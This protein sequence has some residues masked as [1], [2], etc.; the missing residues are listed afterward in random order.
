[1]HTNHTSNF[2]R[3]QREARKLGCPDLVELSSDSDNADHL[4]YLDILP[5]RCDAKLLPDAVAEFQGRPVMYLVDSIEGD[6]AGYNVHIADL[7]QL[8]ANRSEHACVAIFRPGQVDVYP[9]NLDR[10]LVAT[11]EPK[12]ITLRDAS[13][14]LFFH[15]IATG[16]FRLK[17]QPKEADYVFE[18]INA[19]LCHA[20]E[21][22]M[23][24]LDSLEILSLTGRALF[25]RFLVDRKIARPEDID[26]ISP[27]ARTLRHAFSNPSTASETA[28]WLDETF[29]GDLLPLVPEIYSGISDQE[30][31][32]QYRRYYRNIGERTNGAI[33]RHLEAIMRGWESVSPGEFQQPLSVDWDDLNFAHIPV[34]VLSQVYENFSHQIDSEQS[35][36]RS[37][38]YTPVKIARLMV[39]EA[40]GAIADPRKI[41]VL[42]S[43][44]GAGV[45]LVLVFRHLVRKRW[46]LDRERPRKEVIHQILYEQLTGFDVSESALRLASL[47]LYISAIEVN[48]TTRPA[49]LLKHIKPLK[50]NVLFNVDLDG[51]DGVT[52]PK[53][54]FVLGSLSDKLDKRFNGAFDVV[55]GN[56]PWTR[57]RPTSEK[58]EEKKQQRVYIASLNR[59]FDAIG[60]RVLTSRGF[61]KLAA[62]YRTPDNDPDWPFLWRAMEWAKPNGVIA[63]A[64]PARIILKQEGPGKEARDALLQ[65]VTIMG[66]LNG[67]DLEET[68]VWPNMKLPFMLLFARNCNA[69]ETHAF[70]FAT[71]VRENEL[72]RRGEFR[73]DY[74]SAH[75][76]DV[77]KVRNQ[78]WLLKT[79]AVGTVLDVEVMERLLQCP[80]PPLVE[81]WAGD[82]N[83]GKGFS[84][85]PRKEGE[86]ATLWMQ[87]LHIFTKPTE[88][89]IPQE[90][91]TF[92][93]LYG[94][95]APYQ[96][97]GE[98]AYKKPL[99]IMSKSVADD[100]NSLESYRFLER[101]TGY[102]NSFYG[103][104]TGKHP[105]GKVLIA[106]LHILRHSMLFRY[107]LLNVSAEFGANFR[108]F[109]KNEI[110]LLPF[111][112]PDDLQSYQKKRILELADSLDS[113]AHGTREAINDFI[114]DLY[115]LPDDD[116]LVIRE[117]VSYQAPFQSVRRVADAPPSPKAIEAFCLE[118]RDHLA[119][120]VEVAD[121]KLKVVC[122]P[123]SSSSQ[124]WRFVLLTLANTVPSEADTAMIGALMREADKTASSR[125]VMPIYD[126]G[127]VLLGLLN[128]QR[129]W[130]R[131]R[132]HLCAR[133]IIRNHLKAFPVS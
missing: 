96:T 20:T 2:K 95:V 81:V 87:K 122:L 89:L 84:L 85:N 82:L 37:V 125:V 15:S 101:D 54:G 63:L 86:D 77:S 35:R 27:K 34:G 25:F 93:E 42:D 107:W 65:A 130:T 9:I 1:M 74:T 50:G 92:K 57:L 99:L 46:E 128:R 29:N 109:L 28:A 49:N 111:P 31:R 4:D 44:C 10:K 120:L 12:I 98:Q 129:Y 21:A 14:P 41:R 68:D 91:K 22:L 66:V 79:L 51:N 124:H 33:F 105:D 131:S 43:S 118:L 119:S 78:S 71:P 110:D 19:L 60:R 39:A 26:R 17:E 55:I 117:T 103:Y 83:Q 58:A 106:L 75:A 113:G 59:E 56:P 115:R 114:F 116:S 8:L 76:V 16:A 7:C 62:A 11:A 32:S 13:A 61:R 18:Q 38:H 72:T 67:S 24:E 64:L 53:R 30:R 126:G 23:P 70:T 69:P 90:Q 73:L 40:L 112:R 80:F 45:F 6:V 127:G 100:T 102:N 132:A 36:D 47:A 52:K 108:T 48:P 5:G 123:L 3:L 97:R 104:S 94:K 88:E 133:H 121:E